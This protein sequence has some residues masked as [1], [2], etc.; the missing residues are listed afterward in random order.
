MNFNLSSD[1]EALRDAARDFLSNEVRL[2]E[3]LA[4]GAALEDVAYD[5]IWQG[6]VQL[7]WPAMAIPEEFGGLG[8]SMIDMA[9]VV[10]ETGRHLAP[11]PLFGT[12]AGSWAVERAGSEAQ[13]RAVLGE[14]AAGKLKLALAIADGDGSMDGPGSD[15]TAK[16]Q[17]DAWTLSGSKSFVVDGSAADKL[18][19]AASASGE[20]KFFLV[21]RHADGVHVERLDWRDLTRQVCKVD[22]DGAKAELLAASDESTWPWVRDRLYLV[23]AAES[24]AGCEKALED[25]LAYAKERVAFG[26]PIGAFQVIKHQLADLLG[27][28]TGATAAVHYAAWALSEGVHRAPLAAAMAQAH[29]SEAYRE[30][31]HR[32]IQI[33]GAIGF[34]W[35]MH[36]HLYYKR[37]RANSEL[38]GSPRD[39]REQVIRMVESDPASLDA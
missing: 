15:V 34:T 12:L 26:K 35:E 23:L 3:L 2:S 13:K 16:P 7:G 11:A 22:F 24:A 38:L 31:T 4:P 1:H 9:M 36:N 21:D 6:M 14:V 32:N 37:A 10:G 39:Q 25:A 17:G 27:W 19:V 29:A 5:R 30:I 18:V 28:T 8:M 20:R 33:F